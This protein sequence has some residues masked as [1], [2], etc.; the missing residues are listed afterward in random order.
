MIAITA[1]T[2]ANAD[3]TAQLIPQL[4]TAIVQ[5]FNTG[6]K[7]ISDATLAQWAAVCIA[8]TAHKRYTGQKL[9]DVVTGLYADLQSNPQALIDGNAGNLIH[10][11]LTAAKRD[12]DDA[13]YKRNIAAG[14][15]TKCG[16]S[17]IINAFRHRDDGYCYACDGTGKA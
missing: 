8:I 6:D 17:G 2:L 12:R 16:G 4:K 15:C 14:G 5:Q 9:T 3:A 10:G 1:E 13:A 11:Y 7:D